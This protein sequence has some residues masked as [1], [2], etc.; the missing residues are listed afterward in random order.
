MKKRVFPTHFHT[1]PSQLSNV[2]ED[3]TFS[4]MKDFQNFVFSELF[5]G[6]LLKNMFHSKE[7]TKSIKI[8]ISGLG[9]RDSSSKQRGSL[10]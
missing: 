6:K 8:K 7:F 9:N 2:I 10:G 3:K 4:I 5:L 1:K